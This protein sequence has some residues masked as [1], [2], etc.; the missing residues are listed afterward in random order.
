[1]AS[2]T[3]LV[4]IALCRMAATIFKIV[5]FACHAPPAAELF[6]GLLHRLLHGRNADEAESR[7]LLS[8]P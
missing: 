3:D 7:K 4:H 1:M 2:A 8:L 6:N 5:E